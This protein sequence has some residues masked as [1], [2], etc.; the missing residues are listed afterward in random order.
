MTDELLKGHALKHVLYFLY[1]VQV[2]GKVTIR[3][4]MELKFDRK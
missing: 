4:C 3:V 1:G 2:T